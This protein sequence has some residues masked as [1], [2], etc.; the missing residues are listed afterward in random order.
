MRRVRYQ[1]STL[2]PCHRCLTDTLADICKLMG[3]SRRDLLSSCA[4]P[5]VQQRLNYCLLQETCRCQV[6]TI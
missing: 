6:R 2:L 4:T 5:P 1:T 3:S